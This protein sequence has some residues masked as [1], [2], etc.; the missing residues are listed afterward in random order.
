MLLIGQRDGEAFKALV[1]G[2][3][4]HAL[5]KGALFMVA[6]A[7]DHGTGTRDLRKL[8]GLRAVMPMTF[9]IAALAALSMAGIPPTFGFLGK[10]T[11]LAAATAH[12]L[13][14]LAAALLPII[15]TI[16]GA[17]LLVQAAIF[18]YG[19]FIKAPADSHSIDHA[20]EAPIGMLIGPALLVGLGLLLALLPIDL[21]TKL[22]KAAASA[23]FGADVK[24]SLALWTGFNLPLVLSA[25]A[26]GAG[27]LLFYLR[28]RINLPTLALPGGFV[29]R[30]DLLYEGAVRGIDRAGWLATRLQSGHIRRYLALMIVGSA[31]LLAWFNAL[32]LPVL[33]PDAPFNPVFD[34]LRVI[35]LLI[36]VGASLASVFLARD[37]HAILALAASGVAMALLIMVEPSPDVALVQIIVDVLTTVVLVLALCK[38]AGVGGQHRKTGWQAKGPPRVRC[39]RVYAIDQRHGDELAR[40]RV[41]AGR[42]HRDDGGVLRRARHASAAADRHALL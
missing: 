21:P 29:P 33:T 5:Y 18:V 26:I 11:L 8:G 30:A 6:G 31:V 3:L 10:E 37:L 17:L 34:S 12:D 39:G 16:T 27:S 15:T 40:R 32:R 14:T 4:A 42:R 23:A 41:G 13:P 2:V 7:I 36:T 24:V 38:T 20:H 1:V 9:A 28:D 19:V 25:I 22:L 35:G